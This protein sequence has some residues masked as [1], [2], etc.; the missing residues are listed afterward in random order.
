MHG[1][2][3]RLL[4]N[5]AFCLV[6][7]L[8]TFV[9]QMKEQDVT[10]PVDFANS[11]KDLLKYLPFLFIRERLCL[12]LVSQSAQGDRGVHQQTSNPFHATPCR[13]V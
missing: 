2:F 7:Q 13:R 6:Y 3:L 10:L 12:L 1:E 5:N 11:V 9:E 8:S 4:A